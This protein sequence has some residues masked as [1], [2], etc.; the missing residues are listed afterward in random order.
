M[1]GKISGLGAGSGILKSVSSIVIPGHE[2]DG[3]MRKVI[4]LIAGL[5]LC[6]STGFA[7]DVTLQ[8]DANTEPDLV[9]Y[10]IYYDVDAGSPYDGGGAAEG[11]SP[12]VI[13]L[14]QDE[15][16][17]PN[18]VEYTIHGLQEIPDVPNW[19]F[20]VT[21]Y[22]DQNL[23][24]GYS[25]EVSIGDEVPRDPENTRIETVVITQTQTQTQKT[26]INVNQ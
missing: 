8:W 22:D 21:A 4:G 1:N 13:T 6:A 19:F 2:G 9:G 24:S 7:M 15:N 26:V 5:L 18:I 20:A 17:D 14:S 10:K 12:I 11:N 25:N 3:K 16:P 23:E